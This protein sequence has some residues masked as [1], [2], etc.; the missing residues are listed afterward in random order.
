MILDRP[1]EKLLLK[2]IPVPMPGPDQLLIKVHACGVCRT[3]LH[4]L[5]GELADPKLPLIPG[6]E[7]AGVIDQVGPGVSDLSEGQ[8]V[9]LDPVIAC[10]QCW[11]CRRGQRQNCLNFQALGVTRAGGFAQHVV[12][13]A[14]NAYAIKNLSAA[15]AAF[16]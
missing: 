16:A 11:A 7:I 14:S 1:G 4:I 13:P 6:H 2:R 15:E 10:G 12:A 5:D 3:D 8:L 9:A